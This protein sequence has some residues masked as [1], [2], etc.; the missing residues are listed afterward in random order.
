MPIPL[1]ARLGTFAVVS[2]L[3][4]APGSAEASG[5]L[6]P[7]IGD[8]HASPAM[9]NPWALYMNPGAIG[10]TTGTTLLV[11]GTAV[12][13]FVSY[14]RSA[15]AL[16]PSAGAAAA[17]NDPKY[18]D[19]NTGKASATNFLAAPF[20][21]II[22]DFGTKNFFAGAGFFAPFGGWVRY[23]HNDKYKGDVQRPG[24]VDGPQ[25]WQ[26][27]SGS[28]AA[29]Y[30]SAA[31]GFR[32]PESR[33]SLG[34]SGSLVYHQVRL[35]QASNPDLSD[36]VLAVNGAP[37]EG[38][39]TLD[40]DGTNFALGVGVYWEPM[41]DRT[42]RLGASYQS[43]PGFG[44]MRLKGK[45]RQRLAGAPDTPQDVELLQTYPDV[46]RVGASYW[47]NKE[48]D[49]RF[50]AEYVRWSVLENQ[51]VVQPGSSC[52]LAPDGGS[53]D[54]TQTPILVLRRNFKDAVGARVGLGYMVSEST[55]IFGQVGAD[56]SAV[57]KET[58]EAGVTDAFKLMGGVG[59]R[60]A[61]S[62]SVA[63][64]GSYTHIYYFPVTAPRGTGPTLA[65]PSRSPSAAGEYKS[66]LMLANVN[67]TAR[68]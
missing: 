62:E 25:R 36:D 27:I 59:V 45:V 56:T 47:L 5:F 53:A 2:L 1:R 43:Q 22:S 16:S 63:L 29:L 8:A 21:S 49:L 11:D 51:C 40:A 35:T 18:A 30:S 38:R 26:V 57:P 4:A 12:L 52:K 58:L 3:A 34:I 55:E 48:V 15:N 20:L 54:P 39:A 14:E 42:L 7:R 66:Q 28:T 31:V 17:N 65:Q 33:F 41:E 13:R 60:Y 23:D 44:E 68:F 61:F 10:G 32:L 46:I 64:A 67:L 37:K 50:D 19:A 6:N 24:A 9:A